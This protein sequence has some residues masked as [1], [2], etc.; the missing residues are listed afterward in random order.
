MDAHSN[1]LR[2]FPLDA[3]STGPV[4]AALLVAAAGCLPTSGGGDRPDD[5]RGGFHNVTLNWQMKGVD[6]AVMS[7]C[8]PGFT[9]LVAHFY[10]A[11][12]VEPPDALVKLPCTPQGTLT[13]PVATEGSLVD[14]D[15]K[16]EELRAYYDYKPQK[17]I[18]LDVTEETRTSIA[19]STFPYFVELKEDT[20]INLEIYPDGGVGVL[21]WQLTSSLTSA[22]LSSCAA[23]DVQEVEVAVRP[24]ADEAAPLVV[25]GTWPCE[26][27]DAQF[28]YDPNSNGFPLI[29]EPYELGSGHT[30]GLPVGDYFVELRA[31]RAGAVVG[32]VNGD[33]NVSGKNSADGIRPALIPIQD[34]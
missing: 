22:P 21:A 11:A 13:Q 33:V 18:W 19:A 1:D 3:K 15:S 8:P 6:G 16:Q 27:K 9:T 28:Y 20:T 5:S 31:K 12:Y 24:F 2:R 30:R 29:D 10:L 25:V 4:A 34:R 7:S 17:E 14:P 26:H 23:A 32:T